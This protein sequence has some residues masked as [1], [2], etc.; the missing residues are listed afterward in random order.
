[1]LPPVWAAGVS[2]PA[3]RRGASRSL[4]TPIQ[5]NASNVTATARPPRRWLKIDASLKRRSDQYLHCPTF[6]GCA[7]ASS[8]ASEVAASVLRLTYCD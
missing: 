1:M 7:H 4:Q 6:N 5:P 8:C 2:T 3:P